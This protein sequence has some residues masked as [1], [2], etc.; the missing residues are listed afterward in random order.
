MGHDM[1][2]RLPLFACLFHLPVG[3]QMVESGKR[4]M[5]QAPSKKQVRET[6][7]ET[8]EEERIDS[9]LCVKPGHAKNITL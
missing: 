2:S 8:G 9:D 5:K 1:G 4:R 7:E 6:L 3:W